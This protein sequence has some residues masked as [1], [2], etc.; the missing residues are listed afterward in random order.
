MALF[1]N[2][3]RERYDLS[4]QKLIEL[5]IVVL[6][7]EVKYF[8]FKPVGKGFSGDNYLRVG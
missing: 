6:I 3:I 2:L 4:L 8:I 7:Y 5:G 1:T